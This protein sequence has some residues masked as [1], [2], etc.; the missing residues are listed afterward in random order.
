MIMLF[1]TRPVVSSTNRANV[2]QVR[3]TYA[4]FKQK[5]THRFNRSSGRQNPI[6]ASF[7]SLGPLNFLSKAS[8]PDVIQGENDDPWLREFGHLLSDE[9]DQNVHR[10]TIARHS[11]I[12]ARL[13][14]EGR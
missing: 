2:V 14:A 6:L 13:A 12:A 1:S 3:A 7:I 4:E 5:E 10:G 8:S 9:D 11:H